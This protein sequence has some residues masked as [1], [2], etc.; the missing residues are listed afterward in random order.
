M[1]LKYLGED[2]TDKPNEL[3]SAVAYSVPLDLLDCSR[4]IHKRSNFFYEQ[5][6]LMSFFKKIKEKS[7]VFTEIDKTK[8]NQVKSVY[9]FDEQ[10]TA[11]LSGYENAID[12]YEKCSSINFIQGIEISTLVVNALNDPF[13]GAKCF[14]PSEFKKT[15]HVVFEIPKEGGHCGFPSFNN[16]GRYWSEMRALEFVR[17][18]K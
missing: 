9:D 18:N 8:L 13:L 6:F 11:P 4:Q 12:Y 2:S 14:D 15:N 16:H 5:R 7:E 3:T 10:Y 1:V 17:E